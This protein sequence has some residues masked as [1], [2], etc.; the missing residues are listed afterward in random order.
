[1][2]KFV[3]FSSKSG[4]STH[5]HNLYSLGLEKT[6]QQCRPARYYVTILD[7]VN[8]GT[9]VQVEVAEVTYC[10]LLGLLTL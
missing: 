6:H 1:M 9:T 3:T 5:V 2:F 8:D 7:F 10:K 4:T